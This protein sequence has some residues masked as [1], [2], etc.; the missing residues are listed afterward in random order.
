MSADK[1]RL[2]RKGMGFS[3]AGNITRPG[4]NQIQMLTDWRRKKAGGT[5]AIFLM[6]KCGTPAPID[7]V[8]Y[9][10]SQWIGMVVRVAGAF[11]EERTGTS[12]GSK[13]QNDQQHCGKNFY[14]GI[15]LFG[16]VFLPILPKQFD[17]TPGMKGIRF[18]PL[19][20]QV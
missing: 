20:R 19:P 9:I 2:R 12:A 5:A 10:H 7:S 6:T 11:F 18:Q 16:K 4:G 8:Q 13:K 17:L 15:A 14:S 3:L 1:A